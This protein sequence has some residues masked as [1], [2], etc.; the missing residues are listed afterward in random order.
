MV[1][2]PTVERM[3]RPHNANTSYAI[4]AAGR[5]SPRGRLPPD[6]SHP[7]AACSGRHGAHLPFAP[8][9]SPRAR[10]RPARNPRLAPRFLYSAAAIRSRLLFAETL[11][12]PAGRRRAP[13]LAALAAFASPAAAASGRLE[14]PPEANA[15]A[16]PRRAD[17]GQRGGD[18]S[19]GEA[20]N[21]ADHPAQS[22]F[23]SR[24]AAEISVSMHHFAYRDGV[25]SAEDVAAAGDR[26]GGRH[27]VLLLFER[28]HRA[29]FRGVPRRL[30]RSRTRW[31]ATR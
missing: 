18:Q 10:A 22:A 3:R 9:E 14:P 4:F 8:Q 13:A 6:R 28:D 23:H 15:P 2:A 26:A 17:A 27:A 21:P 31:S 30:R 29:P 1:A 5:I 20:K 7:S 24:S 16:K 12:I 19:D 11:L 25:L